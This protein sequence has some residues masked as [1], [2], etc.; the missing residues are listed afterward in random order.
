MSRRRPNYYSL[1]YHFLA[2][3]DEN[4][5]ISFIHTLASE[6]EHHAV[7]DSLNALDL[8]RCIIAE[9]KEFLNTATCINQVSLACRNCLSA[10]N[11]VEANTVRLISKSINGAAV[12]SDRAVRNLK[13]VP[14]DSRCACLNCKVIRTFSS[15]DNN[16]SNR[17]FWE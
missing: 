4:T 7:L 12:T 8:R 11:E 16:S 17:C 5:L 10:F 3:N 13:E 1:L 2:V 6:V 15:L 14:C 9:A